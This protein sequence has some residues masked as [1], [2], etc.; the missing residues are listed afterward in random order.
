MATIYIKKNHILDYYFERKK[1]RQR[2]HISTLRNEIKSS[3]GS[4]YIH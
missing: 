2:E 4:L 1:Y 3:S